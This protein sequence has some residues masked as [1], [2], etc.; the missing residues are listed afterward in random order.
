MSDNEQLIYPQAAIAM[1]SGDL[2]QVTNFQASFTNNAKQK[3][4]IRRRGAGISF[5]NPESQVTFDSIIDEDGPER[6]YW[7]LAK[8]KQIKQLRVKLPGGKTLVYNGAYKE[9]K[10]DG[11]LDDATKVSCVFIGNQ[12]D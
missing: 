3:H 4:T 7:R 11:P 5:G 6:D 12:E 1:D 8:K 9:V 10:T 2:V